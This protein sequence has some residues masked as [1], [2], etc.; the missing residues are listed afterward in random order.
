M[1]GQRIAAGLAITAVVLTLSA[2]HAAALDQIL[3]GEGGVTFC[4]TTIEVG[5]EAKTWEAEGLNVS[6]I[7]LSTDARIQQALA[8]D[9]ISFGLTSGPS[10]GYRVKGSAATT[11]AALAGAPLNMFISVPPDG[12]IK[13]VDDLK[14]KTVGVT[15]AAGLTDWLVREL[16][17]Q[18]GWGTDSI[19]TVALGA[20]RARLAA[21]KNG[22]IDALITASGPAFE[23][24]DQHQAKIL[25]TF[26]DYVPNFHTHVLAARDELIAQNPQLIERFLRAWF[27]TVRYMKTHKDVVVRVAAKSFDITEATAAQA[28]EPEVLTMMSDDG[29]FSPAAVE[30]IRSSLVP[31]GILDTTP[32]A[33]ALYIDHF[34]PVKF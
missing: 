10:M 4:W 8:S 31:L 6:A 30:V 23:L 27:K 32:D 22:D 28:Y 14:G 24:Q 26:G 11:I 25:L 20:S 1:F 17:H 29:A 13:T 15:S 7:Q 18:K 21:M 16:A 3:V 33:K 9:S 5:Q 12:S 19:H 2:G 34:V